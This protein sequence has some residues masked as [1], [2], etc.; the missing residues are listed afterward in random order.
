MVNAFRSAARRAKD[1]RCYRSIR[2]QY[3]LRLRTARRVVLFYPDRPSRSSVAYKLCALLGHRITAN[4]DGYYDVAIRWRDRTRATVTLPGALNAGCSDIS[5][6]HVASVF[7]DVFGYPLAVDPMT[8]RAPMV[9]KSDDNYR[10]DGEIIT[11]PVIAQ[12]G[13]VY[14]R[15]IDNTDGFEAVDHRVAIVGGAVPLVYL[16]RR[17]LES[18]FSNTNTTVAVHGSDELFTTI[19]ERQLVTFAKRMGLDYGEMDVLRDTDGRIYVVDVAN[20]PAGP[21]N[22]LALNDCRT[23]LGLLGAAFDALLASAKPVPRAPPR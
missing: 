21:P 17:P 11:G 12:P 1:L 2:R 5:K 9:E 3:G 13:K 6:A 15:L 16:K 20:T 4:P 8:Y 14:Q 18:R 10:H 23:A 19:E 7:A 22:G